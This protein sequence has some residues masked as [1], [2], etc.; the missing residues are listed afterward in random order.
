MGA[1]VGKHNTTFQQK[2]KEGK[3]RLH[4]LKDLSTRKINKTFNI[5]NYQKDYFMIDA[6]FILF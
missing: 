1:N 5:Q 4:R 3:V 6:F 2:K